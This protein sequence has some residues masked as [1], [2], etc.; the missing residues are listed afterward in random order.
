MQLIYTEIEHVDKVEVYFL[1]MSVYFIFLLNLKF[2]HW[3][4]IDLLCC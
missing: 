4:K 1:C 2:L 3:S